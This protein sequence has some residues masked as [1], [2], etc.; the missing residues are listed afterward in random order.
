MWTYGGSSM[1]SGFASK[2]E[3]P[4]PNSLCRPLGGKRSS[5]NMSWSRALRFVWISKLNG[6]IGWRHS[7]LAVSYLRRQP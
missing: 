2:S 1:Q 6:A 3:Q 5:W 7:V 4:T